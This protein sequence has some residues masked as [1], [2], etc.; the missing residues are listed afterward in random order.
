MFE[1]VLKRVLVDVVAS[2]GA[3]DR[4]QYFNGRMKII[5]CNEMKFLLKQLSLFDLNFF[6][7]DKGFY[8]D[9]KHN[10]KGMRTMVVSDKRGSKINGTILAKDQLKYVMEKANIKFCETLKT[11]SEV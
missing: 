5:K 7:G 9:D 8:L 2:D 6:D 4:R 10:L 1:S 3:S 11:L